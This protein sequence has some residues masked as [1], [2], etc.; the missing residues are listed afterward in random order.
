MIGGLNQWSSHSL[1]DSTTEGVVLT[2]TLTP[3]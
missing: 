1:S 3:E 2:A